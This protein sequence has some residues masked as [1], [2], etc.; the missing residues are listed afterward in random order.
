MRGGALPPALLC[1]A[2]GFALAYAPRR[3]AVAAFAVLVGV[4]LAASFIAFDP[5]WADALFLGC[6][7]GVVLSVASIYLPGGY[8]AR[9]AIPLAVNAG[10]W[11]GAVVAVSGTRADLA[12]ALPAALI[13]LPAGWLVGGRGALVVKV[14]ASWLVAVAILAAAVPVT[15]TPGYA[16]DHME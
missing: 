6:W 13:C 4:S 12:L 2:L 5:A 15:P 3:L 10:F 8:A 9:L 11:S 14:A 16:P 7:A 1:A